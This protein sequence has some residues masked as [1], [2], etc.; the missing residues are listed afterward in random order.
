MIII[1]VSSSKTN[2]L[3]L[4]PLLFLPSGDLNWL[5]RRKK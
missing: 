2:P 5:N 1:A 3:H 4:L